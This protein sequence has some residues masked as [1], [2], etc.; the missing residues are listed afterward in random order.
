[1]PNVR[2]LNKDKY[3]ISKHRFLELYHFCLQYPEW[4]KELT[5]LT[6]TVKAI[7]YSEEIKGTGTGSPTERLAIKRAELEEKCKMIEQAAIEADAE[8]YPYILKGVTEEYT[9]F[10]Y[11]KQTMGIPCGKNMYYD[12]R[13]RFFWI[14]SRKK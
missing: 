10:R 13:R 7:G 6:D 5:F 8:I 11:L 9:S 14:L 3:K 1:M 2:T 12:R 4:K